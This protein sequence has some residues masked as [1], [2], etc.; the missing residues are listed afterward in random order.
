M[1]NRGLGVAQVGGDRQQAAVVHTALAA[2]IA[3][4]TATGDI[5][6]G[7]PVAG[8]GDPE[9]A[10]IIGMFVNTLVLRTPID[11]AVDGASLVR[12]VGSV[13]AAAFDN[14]DVP[15][16]YL[17]EALA[18]T[19]TEA[20]ILH[21]AAAAIVA[22]S[23]ADTLVELGSGTSEKTRILLDAVDSTAA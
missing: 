20:H 16:E 10:G 12:A 11:L 13:D 5:V 14:A 2:L 1:G 17:V 18:P 7:T 23:G 9:T 4:L 21:E 19:R 15:F 22:A 8:R 6:I 3:R